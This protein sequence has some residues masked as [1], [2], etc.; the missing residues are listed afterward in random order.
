MDERGSRE[1]E[2]MMGAAPADALADIR[3]ASPEMYDAVVSR[4]FGGT[5]ANPDL[6]RAIRELV[7]I[8]VLAALGGAEPQLTTHVAAALRLGVAP[9]ELLAL[10]EH[11]SVYA[12]FPRALNA[13]RQVDGVLREAG[14]ARPASVRR[15]RLRDHETVVASSGE[16]GPAVVLL[17]ALGLDWRMWEPIIE[18]LAV[19]RRVFAYDLRGHGYAAGS[20]SPFTMDD[21]A[22]DLIR[23]LDAFELEQAHV[24]GL[25]Y[26]GGVAQ[27]AAV[28]EPARFASLALLA[29]T[30]HPFAAFQDRA[31]SGEVEGMEAQVVPSLTRW[32]TAEDLAV[33]GWSVR[34]ARERIRHADPRDWAAAWRSFESLDVQGRLC[35][36]PAPTLV[37]AGELDASTTPEIMKGIAGR[38]P[39]STFRELPGTP[40]MQTLSNPSLV[41]G[42]LDEFLPLD[43]GREHRQEGGMPLGPSEQREAGPEPATSSKLKN[44]NSEVAETKRRR[45]ERD[46]DR[47]HGENG[48]SARRR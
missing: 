3:A 40:H 22:A 17:H 7:T 4:A 21:I 28:R 42:V 14:L 11:V 19:G 47:D 12:G 38:I 29:T 37:L 30:D 24:V 8:A 16:S 6:D 9:A 15:L 33:N 32:F 36:L 46:D 31:R 23:V 10:C 34:Y 26:G 25:S 39:G 27:T 43:I 18:R 45:G 35:A 48:G 20:P 2:A 44:A 5:L 41:A 1:F 13:L